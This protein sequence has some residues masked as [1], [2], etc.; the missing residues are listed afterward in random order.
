MVHKELQASERRDPAWWPAAEPNHSLDQCARHNLP[1]SGLR[2]GG[3]ES[4]VHKTYRQGGF[5]YSVTAV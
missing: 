2:A 4:G 5:F 1:A 3:S